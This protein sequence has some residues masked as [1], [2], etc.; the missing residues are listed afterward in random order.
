MMLPYTIFHE[1]E[2]NNDN[3]TNDLTSSM[4]DKLVKKGREY[5]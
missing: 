4:Y 1:F 5:I 2:N 3:N